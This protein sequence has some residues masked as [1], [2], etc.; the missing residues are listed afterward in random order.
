MA[1]FGFLKNKKFWLWLTAVFLIMILVAGSYAGYLYFQF[2][3]M[4]DDF[5]TDE[6]VPP[7]LSASTKPKTILLLGTDNREGHRTFLTDVIMVVSLNPTRKTATLASLPRDTRMHPPGFS[8][9]RKANYF[10]AALRKDPD[11]H[12]KVKKIYSDYLDVPIDYMMVLDFKAFARTIDV[13][14]G[15]QVNVKRDMRYNDTADGTSIDLRKGLQTLNGKQAL[16]YVRYRKSNAGTA[17]TT[18]FDRNERQQQV[19]AAMLNNMRS[20]GGLLSLGQIFDAMGENVRS[21]IP[22]SEIRVM[23]N[24]YATLNPSNIE[25][26]HLQGPWR[27]PFVYLDPSEVQKATDALNKQLN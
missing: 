18:D 2:N 17:G 6:V 1:I 14:G 22:S 7:E 8:K 21:D 27:S 9:A 4:I 26:V 12:A 24:T 11:Y 16:D 13:L 19:I 10:Y 25:Y 5:G 3:K 23:M 20:V 15:V